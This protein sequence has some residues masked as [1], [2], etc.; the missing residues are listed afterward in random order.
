MWFSKILKSALLGLK[1]AVNWS[2]YACHDMFVLWCNDPITNLPATNL[3][4]T[5]GT[6]NGNTKKSQTH[7]WKKAWLSVVGCRIFSKIALIKKGEKF[8]W[9]TFLLV[10]GNFKERV[11]GYLVP[12]LVRNFFCLSLDIFQEEGGVPDSKDY[13]VLFSA[14]G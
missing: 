11:G 6:R 3:N 12:K 9:G 8:C 5:R 7:W 1:T 4:Q 10:L 2:L 13:K 14:L